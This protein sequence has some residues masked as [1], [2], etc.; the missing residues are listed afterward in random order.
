MR[1]KE[2]GGYLLDSA[3]QVQ[4]VTPNRK[5]TAIGNTILTRLVN[6]TIGCANTRL[7]GVFFTCLLFPTREQVFHHT[8][9]LNE[10][11]KNTL[12]RSLSYTD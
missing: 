9:A 12:S 10:W 8:F 1:S 6:A 7:L 3:P 2:K 11:P 5:S 4:K